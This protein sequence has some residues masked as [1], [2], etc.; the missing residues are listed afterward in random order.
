VIGVPDYL[1]WP[2]ALLSPERSDFHQ[3]AFTRSGGPS[4]E[5]NERTIKTNR[6]YWR[7]EVGPIP[8]FSV[9]Q[10]RTWNALRTFLGGKSGIIAMP[11][12]TNHFAPYPG[13][14]PGSP[15]LVAHSDGSTFSDGTK[16]RTRYIDV[17]MNATATLGATVVYLKANN[18]AADLT[19][20]RF[21]YQHALYE[22]GPAVSISGD[23]WQVPVFPAIRQA[24]PVGSS[25]ECDEPTCLMQLASDNEMRAADVAGRFVNPTI[26]LVE[27]VQYWT[28]LANS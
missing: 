6:G 15:S 8:L 10:R 1:N 17:E 27:A 14:V 4:L 9:A 11:V 25:L 23:V 13:G 18:A 24:I 22:T 7:A 16:Y 19:G 20:I 28:D 21:S 3:V 12:Y 26:N 5:G 2:R